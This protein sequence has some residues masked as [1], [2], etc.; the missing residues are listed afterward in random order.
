MQPALH[1]STSGPYVSPSPYCWGSRAVGFTTSSTTCTSSSSIVSRCK[2]PSGATLYGTVHVRSGDTGTGGVWSRRLDDQL[3][4]A[5]RP[6][7]PSAAGSSSRWPEWRLR[8]HMPRECACSRARR[9]CRITVL[10]RSR[11]SVAEFGSVHARGGLHDAAY[12]SSPGSPHVRVHC[13]LMLHGK[14]WFTRSSFGSPGL[15]AGEATGEAGRGRGAVVVSV[16]SS[17]AIPGAFLSAR[18]LATSLNFLQGK[19][20]LGLSPIMTTFTAFASPVSKS[21][22]SQSLSSLPTRGNT[23]SLTPKE[24]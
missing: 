11:V 3:A 16:I 13:A 2:S 5:T 21:S 10:V 15:H 7:P 22:H 14:W 18:R 6:Y 23:N 19:P 17:V 12:P 1:T 4:M 24:L 9:T 20:S 8:W